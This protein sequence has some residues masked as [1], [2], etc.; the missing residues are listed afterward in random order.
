MKVSELDGIKLNDIIYTIKDT[1]CGGCKLFPIGTIGTVVEISDDVG[2]SLPYRIRS[3]RGGS[4]WYSR[5]MII[6]FSDKST[7]S[8]LIVREVI[9]ELKVI[10]NKIREKGYCSY[11]NDDENKVVNLTD[12]KTAITESIDNMLS[13]RLEKDGGE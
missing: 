9:K 1:D 2:R 7:N 4:W 13:R 5:D 12:I 11:P 8:E 3:E 6:P 10:E